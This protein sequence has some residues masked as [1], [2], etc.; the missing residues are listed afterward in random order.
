M[1]YCKRKRGKDTPTKRNT[2]PQKRVNRRLHLLE[3]ESNQNWSM[4]T[5]NPVSEDLLSSADE[6]TSSDS[7]DVIRPRINKN[8]HFHKMSDL[9]N[10]AELLKQV[11][12]DQ[13]VQNAFS[14]ALKPMISELSSEIA[15]KQQITIDKLS[16]TVAT[17]SLLIDQLQQE[18]R[19]K[20]VRISGLKPRMDINNGKYASAHS[21]IE[22]S[23]KLFTEKLGVTIHKN[24]IDDAFLLGRPGS[25][26]TV[27]LKLQSTN[28]KLLIMQQRTKLKGSQPYFCH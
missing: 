14:T 4:T 8:K 7:Y 12:L 26:Q 3:S 18:N 10:F 5:S 24:E 13:E 22:A 9:N 11:M 16:K 21:C 6:S 1:E 20:N 28:A 27:V 15:A 23:V 19:N 2:G 17:Q 25:N